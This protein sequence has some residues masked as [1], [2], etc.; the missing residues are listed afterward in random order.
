[1]DHQELKGL[2]APVPVKQKNELRKRRS[3]VNR[4]E[5]GWKRKSSRQLHVPDS[6][7][8]GKRIWVGI[9]NRQIGGG[10]HAGDLK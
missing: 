9:G 2:G 10:F 4:C 8:P 5:H 1:M 3:L 6:K 7:R